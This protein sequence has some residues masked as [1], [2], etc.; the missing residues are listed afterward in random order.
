LFTDLEEGF[1][2]SP[3]TGMRGEYRITKYLAES[4]FSVLSS[5]FGNDNDSELTW[6]SIFTSLYTAGPRQGDNTEALPVTKGNL[7]TTAKPLEQAQT[8]A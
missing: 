5:G 3:K 6:D 2:K 8:A 7:L 1:T 4:I